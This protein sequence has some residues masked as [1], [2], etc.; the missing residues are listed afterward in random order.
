MKMIERI[1]NN[2]TLP[3]STPPSGQ[4]GYIY[5]S[6]KLAKF[7]IVRKIAEDAL[8]A[9]ERSG[10]HDLYTPD[11]RVVDVAWCYHEDGDSGYIITIEEASPDASS[12]QNFISMEFAK[13]QI[14][15]KIVTEW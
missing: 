7:P 11:L 3:P 2:K 12:L 10:I 1:T 15:V 6:K 4:N 9:F 14:P 13:E 5:W 8:E